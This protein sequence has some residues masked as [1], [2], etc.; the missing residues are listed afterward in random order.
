MSVS[1]LELVNPIDDYYFEKV[2]SALERCSDNG[3]RCDVCP[4]MEKCVKWFDDHAVSFDNQK[5]KMSFGRS[6]L[7]L[8]EFYNDIRPSKY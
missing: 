6:N 3:I 7:L 1:R 8:K 5:A 4:V 2:I